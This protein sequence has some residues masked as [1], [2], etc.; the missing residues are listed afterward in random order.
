LPA[1]TDLFVE[2][3]KVS[4]LRDYVGTD[5]FLTRLPMGKRWRSAGE[6]DDD[7]NKRVDGPRI[8]AVRL[9]GKL[10]KEFLKAPST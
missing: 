2:P 3:V 5:E 4:E 9:M 6:I 7:T 10:R 8:I 1:E